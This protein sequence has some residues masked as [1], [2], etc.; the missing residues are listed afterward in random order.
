MCG[1]V[2]VSFH[3]GAKI[4][5]ELLRRKIVAYMFTRLLRETQERGEDA[6][7]VAA[8]FDNGWWMS[9][10]DAV[11]AEQFIWGTRT[12]EDKTREVNQQEVTY[13]NFLQILLEGHT[14]HGPSSPTVILGHCRKKTQGSEY[15]MTNNHPITIPDSDIVCVH[16]GSVKNDAKI[17]SKLG[18][19]RLGEV[20]S[21]ALARLFENEVKETNGNMTLDNMHTI[22]KR[23]DGVAAALMVSGKTPTKL[24]G[25]RE[26][27]PMVLYYEKNLG[28][29]FYVSESKFMENAMGAFHH[30][31]ISVAPEL[32]G[33]EFGVEE[34]PDRVAL[35]VDLTQSVD[36]A[37]SS[38]EFPF[39]KD[40]EWEEKTTTTTNNDTTHTATDHNNTTFYK[41][42]EPASTTRNNAREDIKKFIDDK[43]KT[44]PVKEEDDKAFKFIGGAEAVANV[45]P[46][47]TIEDANDDALEL[48]TSDEEIKTTKVDIIAEGILPTETKIAEAKKHSELMKVATTVMLNKFGTGKSLMNYP[49]SDEEMSKMLDIPENELKTCS[50]Q[51]L[52]AAVFQLAA[53]TMF[54]EGYQYCEE[55]NKKNVNTDEDVTTTDVVR[56]IRLAFLS[57]LAVSVQNSGFNH[58]TKSSV[59]ETVDDV[60]EVFELAVQS[61][62][63]KKVGHE[64]LDKVGDK[65]ITEV[66]VLLDKIKEISNGSEDTITTV[67]AVTTQPAVENELE[68]ITVEGTLD[69]ED[70]IPEVTPEEEKIGG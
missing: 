14:N 26:T 49:V 43:N 23:Y 62:K 18:V 11:K 50:R 21:E 19:K 12:S 40:T 16:N 46:I 48:D 47:Y 44:A 30:V 52:I 53:R 20:D 68:I 63:I 7:G 13:A 3:T 27:R 70:T 54:A 15:N 5:D 64:F 34:V 37:V 9:V 60:R 59:E 61:G 45:Y 69:E 35:I 25:I 32:P 39:S 2:G 56:A 66:V 65:E 41:D 31:L 6:T 22:G 42:K 8:M 33:L 58:Y 38:I 51:A 29:I 28:V 4:T 67:E 36:K 24:Y 57:A 1:I 10:R 55:S 17:M